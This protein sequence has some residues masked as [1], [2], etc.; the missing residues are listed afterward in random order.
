MTEVIKKEWGQALLPDLEMTTVPPKVRHPTVIM[1]IRRPTIV[2]LLTL[3]TMLAGCATLQPPD[4]TGPEEANQ[5]IRCSILPTTP[6][7]T[8][9]HRLLAVWR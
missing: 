3:A 5:Y 4:A 7:E 9:R 8:P 2:L 1:I 6:A